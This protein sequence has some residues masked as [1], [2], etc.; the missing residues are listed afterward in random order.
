MQ[1]KKQSFN[2]SVVNVAVG[3]AV[4]LVSQL[5]VFPLVGVQSTFNQNLKISLY[6]T[7]ISLFRSYIIRRVFNKKGCKNAKA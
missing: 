2:E 1:S 3:Y 7:I 6:F 4:A 5:I